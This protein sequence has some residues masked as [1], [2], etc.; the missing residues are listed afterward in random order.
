MKS[1]VLSL[2]FVSLFVRGASPSSKVTSISQ[3]VSAPIIDGMLNDSCWKQTKPIPVIYPHG[4]Y[5]K[6][7]DPV[8][9]TTWMTW[10][11]HYLYLAYEVN[12]TNL[13]ALGTGRKT[14]PPKNRRPQSLEY[15]PEKNLDL[16]EFFISLGNGQFFWEIHHNAANHLN[17]LW[18]E[19]PSPDQLVKIEKP[20]YRHVT[21]H[22]N[23]YLQDQGTH[24]LKRAVQLKKK[25]NNQPSILNLSTDRDTGYTGEL[26]LPW[27]GLLF[28]QPPKKVRSQLKDLKLSLLAVN[29]N[30]NRGKAA[31]YS[32]GSG[33]PKLMYH[34]SS[35]KWPVYR[36]VD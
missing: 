32:S 2:V 35:H 10:D 11:S 29:L 14:G 34:F 5:G 12:D 31:Y 17:T 26:R 23:H 4:G 20:V 13:V 18:I 9:M 8:P 16:A 7:P 6:A 21:F 24:T 30:G 33:M 36:L 27:A 28:N 3:A 1:I 19:I 22:R 25:A 15:A